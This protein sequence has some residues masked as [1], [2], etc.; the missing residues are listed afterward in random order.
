MFSILKSLIFNNICSADYSKIWLLSYSKYFIFEIKNEIKINK[1][2]LNF[3][4]LFLC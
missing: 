2:N 3:N 1:F 4:Y